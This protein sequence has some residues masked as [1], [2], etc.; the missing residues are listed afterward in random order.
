MQSHRKWH[1]KQCNEVWET[2]VSSPI[3][4]LFILPQA[5]SHCNAHQAESNSV[6][7]VCVLFM[8]TLLFEIRRCNADTVA[9]CSVHILLFNCAQLHRKYWRENRR[10]DNRLLRRK[11]AKKDDYRFACNMITH[12]ARSAR[13]MR[14]ET[15][16]RGGFIDAN[17]NALSWLCAK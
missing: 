7:I 6:R 13:R 9:C 5:C 10:R 16:S 15:A 1:S 11:A 17:W 12:K 2:L 3:R 8:F 4:F 14:I